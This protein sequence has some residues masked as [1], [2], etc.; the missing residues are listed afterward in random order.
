M[1]IKEGQVF[2][3]WDTNGR[4]SD[5]INAISIYL[6]ILQEIKE[7]YPYESWTTYPDSISQYL[8]YKKAIEASPEVFSKHDKYDEIASI[9]DKNYLNFI[10]KDCQWINRNFIKIKENFDKNIEQRARHYT[11]NLERMGLCN[12][13]RVIT[14]AGF[15][16]LKGEIQRD[17]IENILPLSD[18]NICLIRQLMKLKIYICTSDGKFKFYSPFFMSLYLLLYAGKGIGKDIF[19]YIVQ[20]TSPSWYNSSLNMDDMISSL[21]KKKYFN[22]VVIQVP[23]E[24]TNKDKL[25]EYD[26]C[27]LIKNRKSGKTVTNYFTFYTLLYDFVHSPSKNSY[28]KLKNYSIDPAVRTKINKAFG[29]GNALFDFDSH[30]YSDFLKENNSVLLNT[31]KFNE[32]FYKEYCISKYIDSAS[33]YSDTTL[34][35]LSATGLFCFNKAMPEL[36]YKNVLKTLFPKEDLQSLVLGEYTEKQVSESERMFIDRTSVMSILKKNNTHIKEILNKLSVEFSTTSGTLKESLERQKRLDFEN[37]IKQKYPK[38]KV[39][40]L[41]SLISDRSNDKIIKDIINVDSSIPTIFEFIVAIAWYYISGNKI[42]VYDCL[43]LTLNGDFE[44]LVH[45]AGGAGDIIVKYDNKVVM[46]E[47]TLMNKNA[48]KR[49]EWEPVLRHAI[50][51][52][53]E[54]YDKKV[55]TLFIADELDFNTINIWRAVAAVPLESSSTKKKTEHVVIMP[56]T[57]QEILHFLDNNISDN[58]IIEKV[59]NSFDKIK[60]NV[61]DNWRNEIINGLCYKQNMN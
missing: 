9:I 7:E 50:N 43:N 55:T 17:A 40:E 32:I 61:E 33:E 22:S 18:L 10:Q 31:E 20:G 46:I 21:L 35:L 29:R 38:E 37:H 13:E 4:R 1:E 26:F 58:S 15:D 41:L 27:K 23:K 2:N 45:A 3:L 48:Q 14:P 42:S 44:P 28:K 39:C 47:V 53:S 51:L 49:G 60:T 30:S 8:F 56:F 19:T 59:N 11:S 34:R 57:I 12:K 36:S 25:S 16:F 24:F 6:N 54:E 52:T 5:V